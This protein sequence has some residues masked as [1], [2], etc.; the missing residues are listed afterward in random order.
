MIKVELDKCTGCGICAKI[1]PFGAIEIIDKKAQIQAHCA[2]CGACVEACGF[3]AIELIRTR[4][5]TEDLS[6]Y[7]DVWVF[8]EVKDDKLKSVSLE[9]LTKAK[10]LAKDLNQGCCALLIG[11]N[12]KD[13]CKELAAYG[14]DKVYLA[15]HELLQS[16]ST[17]AYA[18]II[19]GLISKYK[20]NIVI[21]PATKLGRDLAPR[22]AAAL[23]LGLTADCTGLSIK[24]GLLLQTRPAFGGNVMADII[25]PFTRPQ[26]AT[27]R[28]NV[29]PKGEA[30]YSKEAE[31]INVNVNLNATAIRTVIKELIKIPPPPGKSIEE[32]DI[33]VAGGR[34]VGSKE[35]FKI[36]EEL[37]K[38]LNAAIGGSRV[39]VEQGWLPKQAQV[40]QSG[41]TVSP[42]L[43]I[44]CGISG[45]IQHQVGMK[46][47]KLIIAI[48][49]DPEAP[50]FNIADYG[51]VGDLFEVVPALTEA[52]RNAKRSQGM[53]IIS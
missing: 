1:C 15:E 22:V 51:I 41:T 9:L 20:P 43:Y 8:A 28:P 44:A 29:M 12:I 53:S 35:G 10:E 27:V 14:A 38:E 17:D 47:S 34:G 42:K 24:D 37:A 23:E 33:I 25:T 48:N 16:Y 40:G 45:A 21:Y 52:V 26:M 13:L 50:I 30:N 31:I 32:A 7:R 4:V 46:S 19:I 49:K 18:P 6:V 3:G 36:L 39:A 5:K 2:L 11:N